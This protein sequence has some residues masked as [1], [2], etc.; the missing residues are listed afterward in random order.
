MGTITN[1]IVLTIHLFALVSVAPM[2]NVPE[3]REPK[4]EYDIAVTYGLDKKLF[5][6]IL[7]VESGLDHKALNPETLDAGIGQINY[8][9]A[10][11]FGFDWTRLR[12]DRNYSIEAAAIVLSDFKRMYGEREPDDWYA[13]YNI[14]TASNLSPK[15]QYLKEIYKHKIKLAMGEL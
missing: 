14:G 12:K 9:T 7:T 8:K 10:Q 2:T 1:I 15:Q 13:R 3:Y 5:V 4:D 6:A 11:A